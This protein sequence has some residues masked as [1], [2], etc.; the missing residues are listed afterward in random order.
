M[1]QSLRHTVIA[2]GVETE[3][4]AERLRA[5]GCDEMQGYLFSRPLPGDQFVELLRNAP[6]HDADVMVVPGHPRMA[7]AHGIRAGVA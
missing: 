5:Y 6:A 7:T 2:E 1:A 3:A 4:Q